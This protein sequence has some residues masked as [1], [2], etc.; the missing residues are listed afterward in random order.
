M[1]PRNITDSF[2]IMSPEDYES[3][4][5]IFVYR[6]N[7]PKYKGLTYHRFATTNE[8]INFSVIKFSALRSG[9]LV[10]TVGDKRFDLGALR[11]LHHQAKGRA[12]P[13]VAQPTAS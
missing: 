5:E 11:S 6:R 9:D 13:P 7:G 1:K 2:E 10:L 3:P 4:A 12:D 8:A